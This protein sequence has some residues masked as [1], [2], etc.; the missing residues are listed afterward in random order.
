VEKWL[1]DWLE[2]LD[3]RPSTLRGYA[4]IVRCHL[5]PA[6]GSRR[7]SEL[8]PRDIHRAMDTIARKMTRRGVLAAS[9]VTGVLSVL[10]SAL[11][12]A[13][14]RA[15]FGRI[16]GAEASVASQVATTSCGSRVHEP[17]RQRYPV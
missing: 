12:V 10:R 7:L 9:T 3:L 6:L 1:T 5:I 14:A 8:E 17:R 13:R 11:G 15:R 2:Q 16:S 4:A